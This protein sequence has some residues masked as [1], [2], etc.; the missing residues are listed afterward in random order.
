MCSKNTLIGDTFIWCIGNLLDTQPMYDRR[1]LKQSYHSTTHNI[2]LGI[3]WVHRHALC[4]LKYFCRQQSKSWRMKMWYIVNLAGA[5]WR[6]VEMFAIYSQKPEAPHDSFEICSMILMDSCLGE[7]FRHCII[8]HFAHSQKSSFGFMGDDFWCTFNVA[9]V[10]TPTMHVSLTVKVGNF[11]IF[12]N[13]SN[14]V[15]L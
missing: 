3:H 1:M 6:V 10:R 2:I 13:T 4:K 14:V 9:A 7:N 5:I 15:S 11:I 8:L 12:I